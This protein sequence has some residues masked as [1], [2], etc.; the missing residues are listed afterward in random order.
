MMFYNFLAILFIIGY[1][2]LYL[3]LFVF[4]LSTILELGG[5]F[6][7]LVFSLVVDLGLFTC[8]CSLKVAVACS[9]AN[10]TTWQNICIASR[11]TRLIV[12]R[13]KYSIL[14]I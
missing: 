7:L 14:Q 1:F 10:T 6:K 11:P 3:I 4:C 2:A 12:S 9:N 5:H 13:S 8:G